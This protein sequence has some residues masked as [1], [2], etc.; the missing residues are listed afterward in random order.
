MVVLGGEAAL[1]SM[2]SARRSSGLWVSIT[3]AISVCFAKSIPNVSR[4]CNASAIVSAGPSASCV[5]LNAALAAA[6][7]ASACCSTVKPASAEMA[8]TCATFRA[9]LAPVIRALLALCHIDL[10]A[11]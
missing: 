11:L 2:R 10:M 8:T 3:A 1:S 4:L 5:P 9:M 7:P 6:A